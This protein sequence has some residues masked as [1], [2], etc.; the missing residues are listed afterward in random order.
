MANKRTILKLVQDLGEGI[1][2]DEI[3]SLDE[4]EE[5]VRIVN[6]LKQTVQEILDRKTWEF[7][8][9]K[10]RQLD[11]RLP[12][13]NQLNTLLIPD[14][15]TRIECLKYKDDNGKFYEVT[16]MQACDFVAM[17]QSRT[18]TEDDINA[19][20]NADGVALNTRTTVPPGYWT[21]FDEETITFDSYNAASGNGNLIADSVIIADV[22]PVTDFTDPDAVLNIPERMETLVFNEALVTCNY[23][24]RQTAD[25]RADRVARRQGI[26]LRENEHKTKIDNQ[27]KTYGRRTRS[28]R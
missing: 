19:I 4:T 28:G 25:P 2:T 23:R 17:L 8:K 6:I 27:E 14:D 24:L 10:V 15:V 22:M 26:S 9:D 7:M 12:G 16:Y 1:N 3:D 5:V 13:S 18:E 21:S 11:D 20:I